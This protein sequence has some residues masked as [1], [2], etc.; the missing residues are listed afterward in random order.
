MRTLGVFSGAGRGRHQDA[1]AICDG[2]RLPKRLRDEPLPSFQT[3]GG[4]ATRTQEAFLI[5]WGFPGDLQRPPRRRA[6]RA[7]GPPV[8]ARGAFQASGGDATRTQEPFLIPCGFP[9]DLQRP[10]RRRAPRAWGPPVAARSA[11]QASGGDATRTQEAF[12][13][14]GGLREGQLRSDFFQQWSTRWPI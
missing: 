5:P 1:E 8:A 7:W 13:S 14:L 2:R 3:P 10:P 12:L 9:G 6:P 4:D 11:F